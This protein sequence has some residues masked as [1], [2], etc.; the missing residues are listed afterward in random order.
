MALLPGIGNGTGDPVSGTNDGNTSND[1]Y[2][3]NVWSDGYGNMVAGNGSPVSGDAKTQ[4]PFFDLKEV[5][6]VPF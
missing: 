6:N 3:V 2:A 5:Q 1:T 4:Q